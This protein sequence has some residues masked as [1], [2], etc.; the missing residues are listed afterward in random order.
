MDISVVQKTIGCIASL[1]DLYVV[2]DTANYN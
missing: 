2:N 1:I